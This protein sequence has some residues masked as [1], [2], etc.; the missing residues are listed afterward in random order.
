MKKIILF[1]MKN[2]LNSI[3][4]KIIVTLY[5]IFNLCAVLITVNNEITISYQFVRSADENFI[6]Q[7]TETTFLLYIIGILFPIFSAVICAF[8]KNSDDLHN[9]SILVIQRCGRKKYL[10]SKIGAISL[11]TFVGTTIPYLINLTLCHIIYP[12][13]GYDSAW[14]EAKYLRG[15]KSYNSEAFIDMVRLNHPTFY[16]I[17]YIFV[18]G[19]IAVAIALL[20]FGLSMEEKKKANVMVKTPFLIFLFYV[21]FNVI[22]SIMGLNNFILVNYLVPN[23]S[24]SMISLII[25]IIFILGIAG[26]FI[27]R[28]VDKYEVL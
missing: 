6:L 9:R 17:T 7:G 21:F 2:I 22:F 19:I 1:D 27:G 25:I 16:N 26:F 4:Y 11:M 10:F 20:A 18:H 14:A 15:M 8:Q 12:S 23:N 13:I 3:E 28:G 24:G 5:L